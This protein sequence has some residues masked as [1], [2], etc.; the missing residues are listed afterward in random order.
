MDSQQQMLSEIYDTLLSMAESGYRDFSAKLLPQEEGARLLGVRIP[1]LRRY[2]K[3]IGRQYGKAYLDAALARQDETMEEIFLQGMV[4]GGLKAKDEGTFAE[5]LHYIRLYVPKIANWSTCDVFCAGLKIT[6]Q[7]PAQMWDF[8]QEYP[9]SQQEFAVRF[10]VVMLLDYYIADE[11]IDR[12]FPIFNAVGARR[13]EYYVQMALAWAIAE[14]YVKQREKTEPYLRDM[15]KEKE[16]LDD[17]TYNKAL[18]KIVESRCV[19]AEEKE[20]IRGLKRR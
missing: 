15:R 4:I 3:Q 5:I 6:R 19:S 2:A 12:L 1:G 10:G 20:M 14:C 18:Q 13:H 16:I 7:Y 8:L 9:A 17:F 11:Y